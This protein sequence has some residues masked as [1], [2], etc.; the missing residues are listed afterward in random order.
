[1]S[2]QQTDVAEKLIFFLM[3][4]TFDFVELL[5][6]RKKSDQIESKPTRAIDD[7]VI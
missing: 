2:N 5:V 4:S 7:R 3:Q 6:A 1:M